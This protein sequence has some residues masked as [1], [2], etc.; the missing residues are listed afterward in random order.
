MLSEFDSQILRYICKGYSNI[1][2]AKML[3][4]SVQCIKSHISMLLKRYKVRNR[5]TL[6]YLAGRDKVFPDI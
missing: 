5:V 6:A 3:F 2:I 4:F 1:E